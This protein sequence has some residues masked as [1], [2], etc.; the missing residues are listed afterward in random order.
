MLYE[1]GF[2]G[3]SAVGKANWSGRTL[4]KNCLLTHVIEVK[5]EERIEVREDKEEDV[6]SYWMTLRKQ[7]GTGN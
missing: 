7:E 3:D 5:T 4:C 1:Y 6:S 2:C